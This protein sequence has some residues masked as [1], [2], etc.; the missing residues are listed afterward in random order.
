MHLFGDKRPITHFEAKDGYTH[1]CDRFLPHVEQ[2]AKEARKAV[3]DTTKAFATP[4]LAF[5]EFQKNME[6][7]LKAKVHAMT[8]IQVGVMMGMCLHQGS[9]EDPFYDVVMD[10]DKI[11]CAKEEYLFEHDEEIDHSQ[12]TVR[13]QER[14]DR[15]KWPLTQYSAE[16]ESSSESDAESRAS[17]KTQDMSDLSDVGG[18]DGVL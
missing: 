7:R 10:I 11:I 17:D 6:W 15:L 12:Y 1:V 4:G 16:E 9:D 18:V 5:D 8:L 2:V 14:D 3:R 13:R